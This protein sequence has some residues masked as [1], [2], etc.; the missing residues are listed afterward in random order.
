MPPVLRASS[1]SC[2]IVAVPDRSF[3][4]QEINAFYVVQE[5]RTADC[6]AP[7]LWKGRSGLRVRST[8]CMRMCRTQLHG[9]LYIG[10]FY[11]SKLTCHRTGD[12][13]SVDKR[14][15]VRAFNNTTSS[16][17]V[18]NSS[19]LWH[20]KLSSPWWAAGRDLAGWWER[21]M[22]VYTS[23][24]S[25][26]D[27]KKGYRGKNKMLSLATT[28]FLTFE[29][30]LFSRSI[31]ASC[32]SKMKNIYVSPTI[33][34]YKLLLHTPTYGIFSFI[35]RGKTKSSNVL[36]LC[37]RTKDWQGYCS[38]FKRATFRPIKQYEKEHTYYK[39]FKT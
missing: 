37:L 35:T 1:S 8:T 23:I 30:P 15:F 28:F 6:E 19:S 2:S 5:R 29:L 14:A 17:H 7:K 26:K 34:I 10:S 16:Q 9:Y 21:L 36:L 32:S 39:Q 4:N 33:Y 22:L 13:F 18:H 25:D 38:G 11:Y 31:L 3:Q 12:F 20:R 27:G 24:I